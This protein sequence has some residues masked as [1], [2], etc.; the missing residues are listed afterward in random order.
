MPGTKT[1]YTRVDPAATELV[2]ETL[3]ATAGSQ[4]LAFSEASLHGLCKVYA[5]STNAGQVFVGKPGE[6]DEE[7]GIP[8]SAGTLQ[9][10]PEVDNADKIGVWFETSGDKLVLIGS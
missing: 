4:E 2:Q 10:V 8:V 3:T 7:A 9:S 5:P 6:V 1:G